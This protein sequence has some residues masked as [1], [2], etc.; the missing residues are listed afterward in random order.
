MLYNPSETGVSTCGDKLR[1]TSRKKR[2][3]SAR[4]RFKP[5][6][7]S[8]FQQ[9]SQHM[10]CLLYTHIETNCHTFTPPTDQQTGRSSS[11]PSSRHSGREDRDSQETRLYTRPSEGPPSRTGVRAYGRGLRVSHRTELRVLCME[12][13]PAKSPPADAQMVA[14][15]KGKSGAHTKVGEGCLQKSQTESRSEATT[16]D[17]CGLGKPQAT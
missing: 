15:R 17:R 3:W 13:C 14:R 12:S 10:C 7:R 2:F 4:R 16:I 1:A 6:L 9:L 11:S 5:L 8:F